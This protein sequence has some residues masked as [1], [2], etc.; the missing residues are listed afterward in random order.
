MRYLE[1]D[2]QQLARLRNQF[3]DALDDLNLMR[4]DAKVK[5]DDAKVNEIHQAASELAGNEVSHA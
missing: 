3:L 5:A 1:N 2:L 4:L